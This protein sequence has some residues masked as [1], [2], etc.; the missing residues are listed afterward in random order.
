[1]SRFSSRNVRYPRYQDTDFLQLCKKNFL[2]KQLNLVY[3]Q[4][5]SLATTAL[6]SYLQS[7][8]AC[9]SDLSNTWYWCN[10]TWSITAII[11]RRLITADIQ[12][13]ITYSDFGHPVVAHYSQ[14]WLAHRKE[15]QNF[16]FSGHPI[17]FPHLTSAKNCK[18]GPKLY[19]L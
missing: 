17:H 14:P 16:N 9:L 12:C 8:S 5:D 10:H 19:N 11:R 6:Y 1:M 18:Y 7:C 4:N 3:Q 13:V 15:F 2:L